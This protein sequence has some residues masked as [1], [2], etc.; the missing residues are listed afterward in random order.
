MIFQDWESTAE[1]TVQVN[2]T[3]I[4]DVGDKCLENAFNYS[5]K[6]CIIK[7]VLC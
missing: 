2:R 6:Y 5:H 4:R 3:L 7:G 1:G